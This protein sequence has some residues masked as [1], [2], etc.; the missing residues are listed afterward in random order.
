VAK[1][2]TATKTPTEEARVINKSDFDKLLRKLK[3]E[4]AE[5]SEAKGRMGNAVM[6]AVERHNLHV[7]ALRV[8]RKYAK[9]NPAQQSEFFMHF[10]TYWEYGNLGDTDMFEEGNKKSNKKNMTK[11]QKEEFEEDQ[12][13]AAALRARRNRGEPEDSRVT[14]GTH[15]IVKGKVV[16]VNG[17][18]AEAD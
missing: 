16:P 4:E 8:Y 7:D 14:A 11:A 13:N 2:V 6:V 10:Q 15:R 5:A 1:R 3:S 12:A 18:S 9:K 17:E